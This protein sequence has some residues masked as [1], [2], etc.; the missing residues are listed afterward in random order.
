M[1][2][3]L[4][5]KVVIVTGGAKGIGAGCVARLLDAG[6]DVAIFDLDTVASDK[7]FNLKVDVSKESEVEK[8]VSEVV[9]KFGK[10][11]GLVNCAGIQTYGSATETTEEVWDKTFDVNVKIGRAHV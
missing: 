11:D 3:D 5:G 7:T 9:A 2:L 8:A 10:I 4:S 1:A 6:A